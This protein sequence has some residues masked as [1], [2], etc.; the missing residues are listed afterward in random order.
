M[1]PF[2]T[3]NGIAAPLIMPN[4][5]TDAISPS[6]ANLSASQKLGELLFADWRYDGAE[7]P[8]F[9]LNREPFRSASIIVGGANFGCGS[10]RE[11]A[12]WA[13]KDFGIRS[14][15]APSFGDIFRDNCFQNGVLPVTLSDMDFSRVQTYVES[16]PA[17]RLTIDLLQSRVFLP[18]GSAMAF[19]V[20]EDRRE[21]LLEG[22]EEID[23]LLRLKSR[24]D[25]FQREDGQKR[26]W[27]YQA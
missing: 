13:L 25:V 4:V 5:T 9:V 8:D 22:L 15:I 12:V 27:I 17:P 3:H 11:R 24:I 7:K 18:D 26:P 14:V 21:S 2:T 6:K 20:P 1:D 23:V 19:H 10:S 16:D